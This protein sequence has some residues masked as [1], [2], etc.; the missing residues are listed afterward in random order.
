MTPQNHIEHGET[1]AVVI[2]APEDSIR[3]ARWILFPVFALF[4]LVTIIGMFAS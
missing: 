1:P 4:P 3:E 2:A